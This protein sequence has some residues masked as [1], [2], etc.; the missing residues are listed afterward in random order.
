MNRVLIQLIY[1]V[2]YSIVFLIIGKLSFSESDSLSKFFVGERKNDEK[3][4]FF[5]FVGTWVSAAT[6][7]GF[8]GNVY[9]SGLSVIASSV[10]PWFIGAG[11][12]YLM[13]DRLYEN[14]VLSIPQLIGKKHHSKFLQTVSAIFMICGYIFYLMIQIKGFGIAVS[15]LLNINYKV[16]VFLVY[17]FILYS[18]FGGF[19]SVTKSDCLNLIMLSV[20]IG[21]LYLIIVKNVPGHWFLTDQTVHENT[22]TYYQYATAFPVG[23]LLAQT[24]DTGLVEE[25]GR[26]VAAE[27]EAFGVS[28]WLAPGMNIHRNPLCGRNFEYFS[29]DPL[30]SGSMA[31]AIT[32]GVQSCNG[33][34]TTIK[35]F[36]CN[37]QE[38][39]RMGSDSILSELSLIHI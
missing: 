23:T 19:N 17:L 16:A 25:V 11:L 10:I 35:H 28:W 31:A 12:L 34:G 18:S 39:N 21:V 20:S 26:A 14:D 2:I 22:D 5:T 13:T 1:F 29:E 30:L 32:K 7:L 9:H 33:V 8:T 3:R 4:L 27:M 15:S 37:N 36:A 6:I 24:W 38:D